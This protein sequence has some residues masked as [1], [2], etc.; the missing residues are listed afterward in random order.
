MNDL[1]ELKQYIIVHAKAQKMKPEDHGAIL[2]SIHDD[3]EGSPSSWT[4]RWQAAG[5][6]LAEQ[7]QWL[8]AS[9]H[10]ALARFPYIDGPARQ[11]AQDLSIA[12]FDNWRRTLP[13]VERLE[14]KLPGGTLRCWTFGLLG[15][16]PEQR[17]LPVVLI[18]GGIV[19]LKEQWGPSLAEGAKLGLAAVVAEL[20]GVGENTLPYDGSGAMISGLLDAIADR[21]DSDH[22]YAMTMSFSGHLALAAA[23]TD[24]RI[25]GIV[26][27]GAPVRNFFTDPD[28]QARVPRV[29]VDTLA[30]LTGVAPGEVFSHIRGW[31]LAEDDLRGLRVPLAYGVSTRDEIIPYTDIELIR[32]TVPDLDTL[33]NDDVHGSPAHGNEV[34][35]WTLW[36]VLRMVGAPAPVLDALHGQLTAARG[37]G[38]P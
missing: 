32:R 15:S 27:T 6:A 8:D 26:T 18:M 33:E 16:L 30:H 23:R 21:A 24:P 31:A 20:P 28:W 19:S 22:T 3:E 10:Y 9:R 2:D 35:L 37:T 5:D 36:S 25:R 13:G 4:A 12:A 17:K 7:G 29:T 11:Q 14:V 34:R 38:V 1:A